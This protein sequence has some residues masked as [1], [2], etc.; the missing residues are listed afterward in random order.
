[1]S[2]KGHGL[3]IINGDLAAPA[4]FPHQVSLQRHNQLIFW[5]L[6]EHFCGGTL[7]TTQWVVTA[8]HCY[9]GPGVPV[10]VVAGVNSLRTADRAKAQVRKAERF[11]THELYPGGVKPYD[12]ALVR[13]DVPFEFSDAVDTALLPF[14]TNDIPTGIATLSGWGYI[15]NGLFPSTNDLHKMT[16]P[17]LDLETC[18][19]TVMASL[20]SWASSPLADT[21]LCTRDGPDGTNGVCGGDSGGPLVQYE[22]GV[23]RLIGVVSWG[24]TPCGKKGE[25]SVYTR[26]S[27]YLDWIDDKISGD[28][29]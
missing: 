8:A 17:L 26:V 6:D 15:S 27:A 24:S 16:V 5:S 11:I 21:N 4:E 18:N 13:T 14:Q 10:L 28:D 1:M 19:A 25:P 9:Q 23:P 3:G 12:I 7:I 22:S 29:Q 2:V 20:P